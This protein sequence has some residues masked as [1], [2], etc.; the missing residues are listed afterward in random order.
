MMEKNPSVGNIR[1]A[2]E[3]H[4]Q[5]Q[6]GTGGELLF[7]RWARCCS[8][9]RGE[10][11]RLCRSGRMSCSRRRFTGGHLPA[12]VGVMVLA[13]PDRGGVLQRGQRAHGSS[14]PASLRTSRTIARAAR[15][16]PR[17]GYCAAAGC[18]WAE[19]GAGGSSTDSRMDRRRQHQRCGTHHRGLHPTDPLLGPVFGLSTRWQ[20]RECLVFRW[21]M[22]PVLT[23]VRRE[24][25]DLVQRPRPASSCCCWNGALTF[26]GLR[27][28]AP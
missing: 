8:F 20:V 3:E 7:W 10:R 25:R 26:L 11:H 9:R 14:P 27:C 21:P 18:M 1:E 15:W 5:L 19:R 28:Q 6:R 16:R 22:A 24:Q 2:P 12:V 4:V 13:G 17:R 23:G